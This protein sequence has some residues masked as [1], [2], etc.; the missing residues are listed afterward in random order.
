MR[1]ENKTFIKILL[2]EV[3]TKLAKWLKKKCRTI[4]KKKWC[5]LK[6]VD[7]STYVKQ[8]GT[9]SK[10]KTTRL[11]E[12]VSV[13]V[14]IIWLSVKSESFCCFFLLHFPHYALSTWACFFFDCGNWSNRIVFSSV[15]VYF[16]CVE[17]FNLQLIF[18]SKK[19]TDSCV[20]LSLYV[21]CY[22]RWRSGK[23][24]EKKDAIFFWCLHS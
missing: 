23:S 15:N 21:C 11:T 5:K 10:K 16:I 4:N 18:V 24:E 8:S 1:Y 22:C 20:S 12:I 17:S 2:A 19:N 13:F 3:K 9:E 7:T 6:M 14:F